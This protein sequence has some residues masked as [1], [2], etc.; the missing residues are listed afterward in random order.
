MGEVQLRFIEATGIFLTAIFAIYAL[1]KDFKNKDGGI[2]KHGKIA[3]LLI[4]ASLSVSLIS[5][6]VSFRQNKYNKDIEAS[7]HLR[8]L[9]N[10]NRGLYLVGD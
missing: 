7:K 4:L 3:S 2:T 1:L 8:L 10:I 9:N 6:E 5:K